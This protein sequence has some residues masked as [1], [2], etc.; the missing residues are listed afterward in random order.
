MGRVTH[1]DFHGIKPV[2]ASAIAAE[3]NAWLYNKEKKPY[4]V[5]RPL[6][7]D[8]IPRLVADIAHAA[9]CA[10][11]TGFDGIEL[12]GANGYLIDQ[13]LQSSSNQRTDAY[14]GSVENRFRLLR[15][16][17]EACGKV[18]GGYSRIGVRVS[19]NGAFNSMGSSDNIAQF[20]YVLS[21]LDK[22]GLMY[23]HLMD[24]LAFGFHAKDE[25]F[26]L[27]RAR[28]LFK[29]VIVGNCGYTKDGAE[30]VINAGVADAIAFGRPFISNPDLVERFR[31]GYELAPPAPFPLWY[32]AP[33][34]DPEDPTQQA[35][36][37]SD[38]AT[39]VPKA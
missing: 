6:E 35:V 18:W 5:P 12:H 32:E 2:S 34:D 39:Y 33:G 23:I 21:E 14:G 10:K 20:S 1:T 8:E 26:R 31:K 29:G 22:F 16:V 19:P 11:E 30:A 15:E 27:A 7:T 9:A 38:W 17:L 4:E 24:G 36:G 3:G 37:Y 13:F 28:A 25:V